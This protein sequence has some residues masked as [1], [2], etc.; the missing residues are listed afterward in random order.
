MPRACYNCRHFHGRLLAEDVAYEHGG[1]AQVR[2][3]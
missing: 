3:V 1:H 2:H